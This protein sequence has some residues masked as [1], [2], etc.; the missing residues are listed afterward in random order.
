MNCR[1]LQ[2]LQK[3][4][5]DSDNTNDEEMGNIPSFNPKVRLKEAPHNHKYTTWAKGQPP[6]L[7]QG[8]TASMGKD[9]SDGLSSHTQHVSHCPANA[10][11][12]STR[13]KEHLG[14]S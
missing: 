4:H 8:T 1:Q 5:T 2:D 10:I 7:V 14:S 13:L 3:V 9:H 12:E 6:T 11:T